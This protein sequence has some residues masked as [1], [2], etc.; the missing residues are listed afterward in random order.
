[1]PQ[2]REPLPIKTVAIRDAAERKF[3]GGLGTPIRLI[4]NYFQ[5][6]YERGKTLY[7]YHVDI[8]FVRKKPKPKKTTTKGS[9]K[10]EAAETLQELPPPAAATGDGG[11]EEDAGDDGHLREIVSRLV[12]MHTGRRALCPSLPRFIVHRHR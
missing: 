11:N 7:N 1:M 10:E 6:Q 2:Q 4:V 9:K 3:V 8:G 12:L 5:M